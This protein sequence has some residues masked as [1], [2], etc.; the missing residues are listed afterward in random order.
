MGF[1]LSVPGGAEMVEVVNVGETID[2]VEP[3]E[4]FLRS[5]T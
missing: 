1:E 4:L 2:K 3:T 5:V